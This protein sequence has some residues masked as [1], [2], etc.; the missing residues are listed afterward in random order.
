MKAAK[1]A[2]QAYGHAENL[3][4]VEQRFKR[5]RENR[6]R[7][8]RIP[9][10]LWAAAVS[11]ARQHG[12]QRIAQELRIDYDGLKKRLECADSPVRADGADPRFVELLAPRSAEMSE[13]IVE[14]ENARGAKMRIE[15]RGNDLGG[16]ASLSSTF[17]SAR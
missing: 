14:M 15:L 13:C 12:L 3:E 4:Q 10:V 7:G 16:L 5:W 2:G 9:K 11:M 1:K 17:W 6:K 8:E